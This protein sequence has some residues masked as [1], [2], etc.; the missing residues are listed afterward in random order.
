[1]NE[2]RGVQPA[3]PIFVIAQVSVD[4]SW[5]AGGS[6]D[7]QASITRVLRGLCASCDLRDVC[8]YPRP[9]GGVWNCDE[10]V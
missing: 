9:L 2:T 3:V 10:Y 4:S 8:T 5:L 1:M 6:R 7:H